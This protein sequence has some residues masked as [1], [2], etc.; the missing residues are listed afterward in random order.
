MDVI[1]LTILHV[2]F[3]QYLLCK[4]ILYNQTQSL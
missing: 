2:H 4:K 3:N 1:L